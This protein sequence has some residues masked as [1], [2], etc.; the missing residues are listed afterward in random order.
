MTKIVTYS[1]IGMEWMERDFQMS[2]AVRA[3]GL[4]W[5]SGVGVQQRSGESVE[6][7]FSR[8]FVTI[9][10]ILNAAGLG[11]NNVVD[12]TTLHVDLQSQREAIL[13]T[14]NQFIT[15]APYPAWTA[16]EVKGLWFP[17]LIA[18][19]KVVASEE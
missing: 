8:A 11:W 12:L 13:K 16:I 10:E 3:G 14:K 15:R 4:V 5:L 17:E 19:F 6:S 2:P 18:E 1:P 9:E 7:A